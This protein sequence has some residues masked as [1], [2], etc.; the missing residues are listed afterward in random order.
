M[1]KTG[2][3]IKILQDE[4]F[5]LTRRIQKLENTVVFLKSRIDEL[6]ELRQEEIDV[7]DV[8]K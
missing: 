7:I 4:A 2:N 3:T 6:F 1:G 5:Q 8:I